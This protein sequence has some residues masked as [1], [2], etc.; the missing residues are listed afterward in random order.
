MEVDTGPGPEGASAGEGVIIVVLNRSLSDTALWRGNNLLSW[1]DLIATCIR[2]KRFL[3][4]EGGRELISSWP[5]I[6][7]KYRIR[8]VIVFL[9]NAYGSKSCVS[10]TKLCNALSELLGVR[11]LT[12]RICFQKSMIPS[13]LDTASKRRSF[14]AFLFPLLILK[15]ARSLSLF[16]SSSSYSSSAMRSSSLSSTTIT[17][18]FSS[19]FSS[20]TST[21]IFSA[22]GLI[23]QDVLA[24]FG[25]PCNAQKKTILVAPITF[26][27]RSSR[28]KAWQKSR[29]LTSC[30]PL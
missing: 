8:V 21:S 20:C 14:R 30:L 5:H 28:Y 12:K 7:G 24:D 11:P 16:E 1:S 6:A 19:S 17:F 25:L 2:S 13:I 29:L 22:S 27:N 4:V 9:L 10:S 26:S 3:T 15:I 18:S 23:K